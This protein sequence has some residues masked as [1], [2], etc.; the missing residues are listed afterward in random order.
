MINRGKG[1]NPLAAEVEKFMEDPTEMISIVGGALRVSSPSKNGA[2]YH[3]SNV[4]FTYDFND[5]KNEWYNLTVK[6]GDRKREAKK[7]I[8]YKSKNGKVD[9]SVFIKQNNLEAKAL[10]QNL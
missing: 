4:E 2:T 6:M 10:L 7:G 3:I 1:R 8:P 5:E 9:W